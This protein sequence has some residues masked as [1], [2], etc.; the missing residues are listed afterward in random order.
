MTFIP[1]VLTVA[2]FLFGRWLR[3]LALALALTVE[4]ERVL[5]FRH[6]C[7]LRSLGRS[8]DTARRS[9]RGRAVGGARARVIGTCTPTAVRDRRIGRECLGD[10]DLACR[11]ERSQ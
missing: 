6:R 3:A 7:A 4:I 11:R 8:L 1:L 9:G 5:V 2:R 10:K